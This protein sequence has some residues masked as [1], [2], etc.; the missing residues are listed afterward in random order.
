[1]SASPARLQPLSPDAFARLMAGFDVQPGERL[2]VAVSGGADS[3]ALALLLAE[4]ART[5]GE[6]LGVCVD[7]LTVD[8][9]LRAEARDEAE[10]VGRWLGAYGI[11]HHILTWADGPSVESGVQTQARQ[12]RY[13]LMG[14]WCRAH[15]VKRLF[16]AHHQGDQAE[17]VLMRLKRSTTL[18]G[19]AG[20][21]T[22]SARGGIALCRPLLD[23]T[24]ADLQATLEARGQAWIEDPSNADERFERVRVRTTLAALTEDGVRA[25]RLAAAAKSAARV[26]AVIDRAVDRVL[27]QAVT[28]SAQGGAAIDV[29]AF[30]ALPG[31][32]AERALSRLLF[33]LGAKPYAPSP[34]KVARLARW[35]RGG[36]GRAR[37]LAGLKWERRG[38][39]VLVSPETPRKSAKTPRNSGFFDRP[40]LPRGDKS[41]ISRDA[42]ARAGSDLR[43][44]G[45]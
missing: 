7:A 35:M 9:G 38:G 5:R 45:A 34:D 4:W 43:A 37:T 2:A 19:L 17:T 11:F 39:L 28:L 21:A 40:P 20:M 15:G 30:A 16:L 26:C 13:A 14:A 8:H 10:Q 23:V 6:T 33:D 29:S 27:A 22:E 41:L 3:L 12:A 25:E 1:M 44:N 24:K 18:F 36:A 42:A 31:V 32:V